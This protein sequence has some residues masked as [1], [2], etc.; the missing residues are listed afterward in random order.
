MEQKQKKFF[1]EEDTCSEN[2]SEG[3]L[4]ETP[5]RREV[6]NYVNNLVD[7]RCLKLIDEVSYGATIGL[8]VIQSVLIQKGIATKEEL[9]ELTEQFLKISLERK[10]QSQRNNQ[11]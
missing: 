6:A 2:S 8:M 3:F 9:Q 11:E 4:L 10:P 5:N 7:A 1:V